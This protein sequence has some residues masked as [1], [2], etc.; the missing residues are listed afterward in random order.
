M[1]LYGYS[2][3]ILTDLGLHE[4]SEVSLDFPLNDLRRIAH[5]LNAFADSV[6]AG[7]WR[8]GHRHLSE[9]DRD[10]NRDHPRSDVIVFLASPAPE[11][12]VEG[13]NEK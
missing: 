1:P 8:S 9:F 12:R 13:K 6:E 4:M 7:Q 3:A 5:F 10:W 11:L 2:K